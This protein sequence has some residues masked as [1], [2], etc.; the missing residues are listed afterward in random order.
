MCVWGGNLWASS[1]SAPALN[2]V[3][4]RCELGPVVCEVSAF[5]EF[6][7]LWEPRDFK[8]LI[9][10]NRPQDQKVKNKNLS[11]HPRIWSHIMRF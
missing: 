2:C 11:L 9:A 8:T 1:L 7:V 5:E 6:L 4:V 3:Q 10:K